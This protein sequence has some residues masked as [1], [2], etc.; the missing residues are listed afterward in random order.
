MGELG[1]CNVNVNVVVYSAK[2]SHGFKALN[3]STQIVSELD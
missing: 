3:L 2:V 1:N